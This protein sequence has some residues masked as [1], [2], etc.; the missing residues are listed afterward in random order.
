[1]ASPLSV[2]SASISTS[3][4][5]RK[6]VAHCIFTCVTAAKNTTSG[7]AGILGAG[8]F[9]TASTSISDLPLSPP[10]AASE[11]GRP[12]QLSVPITEAL[13]CRTSNENPNT[14]SSPSC[15]TRPRT[16]S[17]GPARA[18]F[19]RSPTAS[20]QSPT[21]ME[22]SSPL[23]SR[24]QPRWGRYPIL[25]NPITRGNAASTNTPTAY[26]DSTSQKVQISLLCQ[27]P[28]SKGSRINLT[29]APERYSA[30]ELLVRFS[31]TPKS[32]PLHF[33]VEWAQARAIRP[34]PNPCDIQTGT[35]GSHHGCNGPLQSGPGRPHL[36][37][38]TRSS[39]LI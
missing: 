13:S 17:Y 39:R 20:K 35:Q 25:P 33:A 26:S 27:I 14:P 16:L 19:C 32:S 3:G 12:T 5:T 2:T 4:K 34:A 6:T 18:C 28:M 15:G 21:T 24:S 9:R 11:T 8:L 36:D 31:S 7:K 1:M 29:L 22:K 30:T 10:K 23:T 37:L 38:Q